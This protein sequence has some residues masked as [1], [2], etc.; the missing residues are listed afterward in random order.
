MYY[1]NAT[2]TDGRTDWTEMKKIMMSVF[3]SQEV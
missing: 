3:I 1:I 2:A